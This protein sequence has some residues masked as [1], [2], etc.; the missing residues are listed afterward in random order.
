DQTCR[1]TGELRLRGETFPIDAVDCMDRSWGPRPEAGCPDMCWMHA[2]FGADYSVHAI[3]QLD[4]TASAAGQY[5]LAH[6]YVL[7]NGTVYGLTEGSITVDRIGVFGSSYLLEVTDRRGTQ[8]RF[9]GAPMA[10]GY[11]ECFPCVAVPNL[12]NR[13]VA[14]DGRVGYGELQDAFFYDNYLRA[15]AQGKLTR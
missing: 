12:L 1:V 11:W 14:A 4:L 2:I 3:W 6:G 15:Q 5:T 7:E 9:H 10:S 8:H 13:W